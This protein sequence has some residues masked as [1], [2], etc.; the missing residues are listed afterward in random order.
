MHKQG[1]TG[2]VGDRLCAPKLTR[3]YGIST[4]KCGRRVGIDRWRCTCHDWLAACRWAAQG[5]EPRRNIRVSR[6][7]STQSIEMAPATRATSGWPPSSAVTRH[8]C[9][10]CAICS[11]SQDAG[12]VQGFLE[13]P[14][15]VPADL[16]SLVQTNPG[17][18][19][20]QFGPYRVLSLLG[21]G[22]MG[23]VWLA[24]RV[25]GLFTRQVAL[26]LVHPVL[27]GRVMTERFARER[28]IL[29][30]LNHP[31]I[32]RLSDAGFSRGRATVSRAG[33]RRRH[34]IHG[35]LRRPSAVGARAS[36]AFSTGLERRAVCA[37]ASGHSPRSQA[38]EYPGDRGWA[39]A[40][41][42]LRNRETADRRARRRKPSSPSSAAG[43]L[44]P[45]YAAPEQIAGAPITIGGGCLLARGDALRAR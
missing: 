38:L 39:G 35:L 31:N 14:S 23:S 17:L 28:E 4:G 45:D 9:G 25:D 12:E 3:V 21:H 33:V 42:G 15:P 8:W 7:C 37:R 27:I 18:I 5:S 2:L 26:K 16:T 30:S 44:T 24:E 10:C 11:R 36:G 1:F 13:S 41:A 20:K 32:A 34:A 22:G 19:G 40:P 43:L 29:A 6:N